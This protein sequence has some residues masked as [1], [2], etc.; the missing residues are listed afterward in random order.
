MSTA[1][2]SSSGI[3]F[4]GLGSGID[5]N[6]IVTALM[7]AERLP[8]TH[9]Q[10]DKKAVQT[11]GNVV[12][13]LNNLVKGLRDAAKALYDPTA[14]QGKTATSA[15]SKIAGASVT[16]SA[17]QGTFN[18]TVT[19]LASTHT[20]ATAANPTLT[21]GNSL[22]I[23][24]G[25]STK[26]V[27]ME[28]G[29]TL[30]TFADRINATE[31][32]G[33]AASVVNDR[34]VLISKTG[35]TGGTMTIGGTAAAGLGLA[36]TQAGA[37]AAATVN[38]VA[39]TG[40]SNVIEG[41]ISG[42]SLNLAG[43]GTTTLTVGSDNA[44]IQ[45]QAQKFVDAYNKV[46]TNIANATRY[47]A[48]SKTAGTLQGDAMF[49]TF[50][51]QLRNTTGSAVTG[52]S[53]AYDSLAQI[54][55]TASRTGELTLD[56]SKFQAALAKDPD[57]L[58]KVFGASDELATTGTGDGVARRI[59]AITDDFSTTAVAG[60]LAGVTSTVQRMNDKIAHLEDVMVTREQ[61]L[62]TQFQAM[63]AAVARLRSQGSS[64]SSYFSSYS[65]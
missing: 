52:G 54:G 47:D 33:A 28:D 19:S 51:S 56:A 31:D 25:T 2:G 59:A 12:T 60:R 16:S 62:R 5:T 29:D 22:D 38:G 41:A 61:R 8:I 57:A 50:A 40:S 21:T 4:S 27:A 63:D 44:G 11:K 49:G 32:I 36:T 53:E 6:A 43:L 9:L 3:N 13:E 48:A 65:G 17:P 24:V 30:Q 1:V 26:S 45:A 20:M 10:A 23:T 14:L 42:V 58:R 18:I 35:G 64:I 15:D 55:I 37:D 34:L 46:I 7:N 39:V